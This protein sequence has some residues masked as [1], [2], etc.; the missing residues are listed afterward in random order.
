MGQGANQTQLSW[1]GKS[2]GQVSSA[3]KKD[4]TK[5]ICRAIFDNIL[6]F[7]KNTRKEILDTIL[8]NI[9]I[10]DEIVQLI[11]KGFYCYCISCKESNLKSID[12]ADLAYY[13][14]QKI[15][16]SWKSK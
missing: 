2:S 14:C 4:I 13:F 10:N 3:F 12:D 8:C 16:D 1:T 5:V 6:Y 7:E 11:L 9:C 15:Y